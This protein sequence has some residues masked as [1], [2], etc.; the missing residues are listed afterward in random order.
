MAQASTQMLG[1]PTAQRTPQALKLT[2]TELVLISVSRT[3]SAPVLPTSARAVMAATQIHRLRPVS[4]RL[5]VTFG[6][7]G[8]SSRVRRAR[9]ARTGPPSL[10]AA[11]PVRALESILR[12][13]RRTARRTPLAPRLRAIAPASSFVSR[14][15]SAPVLPTSAQL[16]MV[17]TPT[18]DRLPAS[19]HR[20]VTSGTA[21]RTSLV[22]RERSAR[23]E[24]RGLQTVMPAQA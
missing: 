22:R 15:S 11:R 10:Q 20:P 5:P 7:A 14:T 3:S 12:P 4:L 16:V 23:T 21:R 9:L 8:T 13:A 1:Q 19:R 6:T 18:S 17:V 24:L 2:A